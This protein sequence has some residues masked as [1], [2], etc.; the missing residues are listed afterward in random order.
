MKRMAYLRRLSALTRTYGAGNIVYTDE[1]GFKKHSYRQHGWVK[2]GKVLYGY[3]HGNNRK[4]TN[5]IMAQRNGTWFAAETFEENCT[6][7]RVNT[8]LEETL[9]PKLTAP[10]VIV[11]DNAPFHKKAEIKKILKKY[12]HVAL[13]LPPY[14]PDFNPI[15]NSFG[16]IKRRR[17]FLPSDTPILDIVKTSKYYRE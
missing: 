10:S 13:F 17:E 12:G 14:S 16:I 3:V 6:A 2:R 8:W 5:L 4:T 1:S 11:M 15:E 7:H 9:I